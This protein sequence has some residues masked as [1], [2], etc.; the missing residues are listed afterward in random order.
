[1]PT[2]RRAAPG[3]RGRPQ[4]PALDRDI[5]RAAL[6][7]LAAVGYEGLSIEAVARQAG[8]AKTS[9]YRRWPDKDALVLDAVR[10]FLAE[11]MPV[12]ESGRDVSLREDLLARARQ[13]SAVLTPE[14]V[15]VL[16]G[17]LLAT[18]TK[19]ALAALLRRTLVDG[20]V[21]AMS[22]ILGRA[23]RR[24][25]LATANARPSR[26]T[27]HVLPA[28]FFTRLFVLGQPLDEPFVTRAV[29][30]LVLP[31]LLQGSAGGKRRAPRSARATRA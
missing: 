31:L 23:A 2:H 10:A 6:S 19:P 5:I 21:A 25:E 30:D 12:D 22:A 26:L 13:L 3:R 29:D 28:V 15:G 14:R 16:A 7:Q 1:M 18:R 17:L 4:D 8:A 24:G 9:V 20:E 27:L 11:S